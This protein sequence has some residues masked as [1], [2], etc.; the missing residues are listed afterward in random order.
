[1]SVVTGGLVVSS[2][3][4]TTW[5]TPLISMA[6]LFI[7]KQKKKKDENGGYS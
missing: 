7:Q 6:P 1:M 2:G 3:V 5:C 4:S